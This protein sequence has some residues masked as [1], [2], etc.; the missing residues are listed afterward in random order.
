MP[1]ALRT[2]SVKSVWMVSLSGHLGVAGSSASRTTWVSASFF[3]KTRVLET[4]S[5]IHLPAIRTPLY[6]VSSK[7]PQRYRRVQPDPLYGFGWRPRSSVRGKIA[8]QLD[9]LF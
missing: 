2:T 3:R 1:G 7:S 4:E 9:H 8:D 6:H 5:L